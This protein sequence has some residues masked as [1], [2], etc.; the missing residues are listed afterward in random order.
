MSIIS[1]KYIIQNL[2]WFQENAFIDSEGNFWEYEEDAI[3]FENYENITRWDKIIYNEDIGKILD[4]DNLN[5]DFYW[6][7]KMI[8]TS[9]NH[10]EYFL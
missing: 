3:V 1:T 8:V 10:P 5:E 2:E 7:V 4:K 9:E 6:A